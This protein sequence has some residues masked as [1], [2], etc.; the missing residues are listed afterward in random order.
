MLEGGYL[1]QKQFDGQEPTAKAF[2]GYVNFKPNF[3][4]MNL[5]VVLHF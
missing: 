4:K 2:H 5:G 3:L 1:Q